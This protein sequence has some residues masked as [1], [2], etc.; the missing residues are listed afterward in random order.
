MPTDFSFAN[1]AYCIWLVIVAGSIFRLSGWLDISKRD[2][3]W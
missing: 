1:D 2:E 3:L